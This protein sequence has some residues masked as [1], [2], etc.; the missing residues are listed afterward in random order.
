M[1]I[2]IKIVD[3]TDKELLKYYLEEDNLELHKGLYP[4]NGLPA[5]FLAVDTNSNKIVGAGMIVD[6]QMHN[7]LPYRKDYNDNN[8][9]MIALGVSKNNRN[10]GIGKQIV[11]CMVEY[12]HS[13]NYSQLNLNTET[14]KNFY[15]KHWKINTVSSYEVPDENHKMM[16]TNMLRI[17]I[18]QNLTN[19]IS[20]K[21]PT[22]K[23]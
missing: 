11:D 10:K 15:E 23:N 9:W 8:P 3:C 16:V 17:D 21:I 7:Q 12:C 19:K 22:K 2:I 6:E 13:L 20:K 14:A 4:T 5:G 18:Q 1:S